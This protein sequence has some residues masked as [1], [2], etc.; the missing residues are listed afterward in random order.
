MNI[1]EKLSKVISKYIQTLSQ[2]SS[3]EYGCIIFFGKK[4]VGGIS[5]DSIVIG[6]NLA[7]E[8][9]LI[10][11]LYRYDDDKKKEIIKL[12]AIEWAKSL[13]LYSD[14]KRIVINM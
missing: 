12:S 7:Y 2:W 10:F 11:G 1:E 14:Q 4:M 13:N 5:V 6:I 9:S 3:N 8:I